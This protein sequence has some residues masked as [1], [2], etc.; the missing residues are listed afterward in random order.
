MNCKLEAII[1]YLQAFTHLFFTLTESQSQ[2][3]VLCN[4]VTAT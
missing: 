4:L 2:L 3:L 1:N